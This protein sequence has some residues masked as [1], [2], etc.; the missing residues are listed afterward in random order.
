[1]NVQN[2]RHTLPFKEKH[3]EYQKIR[4]IMNM[5]EVVWMLALLLARKEHSA[6]K[7]QCNPPPIAQQPLFVNRS[8]LNSVYV[9][10]VQYLKF[11]TLAITSQRNHVHLIAP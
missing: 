5:H 8:C 3:G 2:H 7:K 1:M 4:H 11:R 9:H 10:A 6:K